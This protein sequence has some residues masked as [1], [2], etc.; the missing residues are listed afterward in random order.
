MS[1]PKCSLPKHDKSLPRQQDG[2]VG[3]PVFLFH[4]CCKHAGLSR[5]YGQFLSASCP[6]LPANPVILVN[7]YPSPQR[8]FIYYRLTVLILLSYNSKITVEVILMISGP[9]K[10][11]SILL[12][13]ELYRE[14]LKRAEYSSRPL[15][16][17][18]RQIL[19]AHLQYLERFP[20]D[21]I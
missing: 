21:R 5:E 8:H 17:Y 1:V 7:T 3:Y 4:T 14:L 9:K 13:E 11:V 6:Y 19:K 15:S 12:P 10:T 18:I 20:S 2:E 16:A